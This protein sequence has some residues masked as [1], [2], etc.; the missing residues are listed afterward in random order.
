MLF[1]SEAD[2]EVGGR[3]RWAGG[4]M[5]M[6]GTEEQ[7]Q[8]PV[9]DSP[10]L[11]ASEWEQ[12]TGAAATADT[13]AYLQAS[14][15]VHDRLVD[16]GV[17]YTLSPP[18]DWIG[19]PRIHQPAGNGVAVV[20]ALA[21]AL[22]ETVDLRLNTAATGIVLEGNRVV[23]VQTERSEEHTSELQSPCNPR[24]PSSA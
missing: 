1:R 24:M 17:S 12:I 6:V 14:D 7:Q 21:A 19:T 8:I 2:S 18:G 3:F 22:P 9:N 20:E 13:L 15:A 23:G 11:A 16:L 5:L 10:E 4:L